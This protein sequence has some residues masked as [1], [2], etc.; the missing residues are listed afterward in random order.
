MTLC[1]WQ[2]GFRAATS[3]AAS[4]LSE[5]GLVQEFLAETRTV[6]ARPPQTFRMD[7]LL[8]EMRDMETMESLGAVPRQ[9]PPV[10]SIASTEDTWATELLETEQN[11]ID[12]S[13]DFL[14]EH[15]ASL[16]GPDPILTRSS[17]GHHHHP[18]L[19]DKWAEQY[20]EDV[21][22]LLTE[23]DAEAEQSLAEA[24]QRTEA[25]PHLDPQ[26]FQDFIASVGRDSAVTTSSASGNLQDGNN[27]DN[28]NVIECEC[29]PDNKCDLDAAWAEE[30]VASQQFTQSDVSHHPGHG[31]EERSD[32][33]KQVRCEE[34]VSI[35]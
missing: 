28:R 2:G 8:R 14:A 29:G 5:A 18:G 30:F 17:G 25:A 31:G 12:W 35:R 33:Y 22:S 16:G 3:G 32:T 15:T 24:G 23:S 21:P 10:A 27:P 9:A 7:S 6:T 11:V 34:L 1:P 19:E 4:G 26:E 20:L 13:R